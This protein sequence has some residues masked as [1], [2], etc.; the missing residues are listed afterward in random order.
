MRVYL[1]VAALAVA[2]A[3]SSKAEDGEGR[4]R[5]DA[6]VRDEDAAFDNASGGGLG[7][8]A[9]D[10][11]VPDMSPA[12]MEGGVLPGPP[13]T[14]NGHSDASLE[15][16][17]P[18]PDPPDSG[19]WELDAGLGCPLDGPDG[20]L[21]ELRTCSPSP[22]LRVG[23]QEG[24]CELYQARSGSPPWHCG[25]FESDLATATALYCVDGGYS[26]T[27]RTGE[28]AGLLV[29][30]YGTGLGEITAYYDKQSGVL[31]GTWTTDDTVFRSC[32]GTV[33]RYQVWPLQWQDTVVVCE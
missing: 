16:F 1:G 31:V 6:A 14:D 25:S 19:A 10:A 22:F 33:P 32:S 27:L 30:D 18:T 15:C 17:G 23:W 21:D 8:E 26:P 24:V 12:E 20:G 28:I 11:S 5:G 4:V 7:M 13:S 2:G 9:A 29:I 3:C